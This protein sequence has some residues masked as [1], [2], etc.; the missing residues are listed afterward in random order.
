MKDALFE[1]PNSGAPRQQPEG[2]AAPR[3]QRPNRAQIELRA[4]DLEGLLPTDHRARVVWEFVEGLDLAVLYA[5][6]K[7]VEG[8]AGRPPIDPVILMALWLYATVQGVGSARAV[9]RLCEEHDAYRWLCGGVSVN[10]HT[11]ADFRVQHVECLDGL[12]TTSVATLRAAG[13]VTLTR[14]AQDG[15]RVRASAGAASFRRRPRLEAFLAEAEEQVEALRRELH[16]DPGA[17]TRRQAAAQQRAATERRQRVAKALEQLPEVEAKKKATEREHARASTTDPEARVMKMADGGFRP[18]FNG[19][20]ATDT[21]AQVIVG[22]DATNLG[23]DQGQL[24]LMTEQ[25]QGRYGQA[26]AEM[27]VDGGFAK[28]EDII[29][30][31]RPEVGCT[32]YAPVPEPR[33]PTRD[34]YQPRPGDP[35]VIAEWRQRMGTEAAKTIYKERAATSEC[36]NAIARNRGLDQF[37]VRGL[38]KVKAVLLWFALAHNLMRAGALR[39]AAARAA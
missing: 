30:V 34:P 33:D 22:V 5:E 9:A 11:L 19:Q 13:L 25:L 26:P 6:I 15:V 32:V 7:A 1:L 36:V 39:Q 38:A 8:H 23:S 10:Y 12:L 4:V 20:F 35:E 27:L 28:H 3:L 29:A 37:L 14:V 24:A 21:A 18:A 16:D 2:Q 31:A 17:T